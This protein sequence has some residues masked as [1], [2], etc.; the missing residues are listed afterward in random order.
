MS[1]FIFATFSVWWRL[2][3]YSAC[4]FSG[5]KSRWMTINAIFMNSLFLSLTFS[6][7]YLNASSAV[8]LSVTYVDDS[9]CSS[10]VVVLTQHLLRILWDFLLSLLANS[11]FWHRLFPKWRRLP[12]LT[13][14]RQRK[15]KLWFHP[16]FHFSFHLDIVAV[17]D[18]R[19]QRPSRI[20]SHPAVLNS[21]KSWL[22][23][24]F[25]CNDIF[26][27]LSY[28]TEHGTLK[29]TFRCTIFR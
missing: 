11:V 26:M 16:R 25:S 18:S 7:Y 13:E 23:A 21:K 15:W 9:V 3:M 29:H 22:T 12:W 4:L 19:R 8:F 27:S 10:T 28:W 1:I 24:S 5:C 6:D 14:V 2:C 20:V 17:S